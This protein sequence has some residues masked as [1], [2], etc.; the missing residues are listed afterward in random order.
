MTA[1]RL[2]VPA[3]VT[4]PRRIAMWS[5]PRNISTAMMRAFENR[6]DTVV[7]DEPF[8]AHYLAETGLEHPGRVA[9]IGAGETDA[10]KVA[11]RLAGPIPGGKAVW[12]QKHMAQHMLGDIDPEWMDHA[13][14][15]FLIRRPDE[16]LASYAR[17]RAPGE[18]TLDDI[19]I[20]RQVGIFHYLREHTGAIPPVLDRRDVLA[21]PGKALAA[22]CRAIDLPFDA[23]M[24]S[25]PPGRR[26]SDGVWAPHW[27]DAVWQSTGF[28]PAD[29]TSPCL[30][31][32]LAG[33]AA[34]AQPCYDE[35]YRHR[36]TGD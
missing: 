33:I 22:L 11:A 35:L 1:R 21:D 32:E 17:K 5:G 12:Y 23:A 36:L 19:G 29:D 24:L 2:P 30:P 16:V 6:P 34:R 31:P 15:C 13:V 3:T 14:H 7:W 10:A 26:D 28:G 8:Y 27:Y 4:V 18:I 20:V 25:W 9:I